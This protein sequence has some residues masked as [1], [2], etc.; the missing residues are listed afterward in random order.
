MNRQS[1]E[2]FEDSEPIMF[3]IPVCQQLSLIT[4]FCIYLSIILFL[5]IAVFCVICELKFDF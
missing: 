1:T 2:D 5:A 4:V 3:V